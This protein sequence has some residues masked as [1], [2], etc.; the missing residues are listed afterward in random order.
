VKRKVGVHYYTQVEEDYLKQLDYNKLTVAD[1]NTFNR[2]F[3]TNR[4]FAALRNKIWVLKTGYTKPNG[5]KEKP[6]EKKVRTDSLPLKSGDLIDSL[7]I[8]IRDYV[9]DLEAALSLSKEENKKLRSR[10]ETAKIALEDGL[11]P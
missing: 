5:P 4:T 6:A 7:L 3:G 2:K 9:K 1:A 11:I 8:D 10:L